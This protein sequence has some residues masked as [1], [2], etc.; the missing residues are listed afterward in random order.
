M[1]AKILIIGLLLAILIIPAVQAE[2]AGE[3]TVRGWAAL[4]A[5]QYTS[6]L[7][8]FN[9]AIALDK[10][11]AAAFSGKAVT[12]NTLGDYSGALDAASRA[13]E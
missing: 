10:N 5:K 6:A 7:T 8:Y 1:R 4:D 12:L 9:N 3:W 2:D 11:S 13:P